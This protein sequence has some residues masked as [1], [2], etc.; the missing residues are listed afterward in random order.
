M[1]PEKIRERVTEL[2]SKNMGRVL[3]RSIVLLNGGVPDRNGEVR[4]TA[5]V[6]K[7]NVNFHLKV[8]K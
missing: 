2:L 7:S 8:V 1:K 6:G 5:R 4:G 3:P